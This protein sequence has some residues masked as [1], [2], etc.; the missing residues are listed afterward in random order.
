MTSTVD[1]STATTGQPIVSVANTSSA[2]SAAAAGGSVINVSQL[3]S[4]LVSAAQAPQ[5]TLI[6]NQTESVTAEISAL[7][8]LQSALSTFQSS[9]GALDTPE[10]L[11]CAHNQQQR[12]DSVGGKRGRRRYGRQLQRGRFAPGAGAAAAVG[13]CVREQQH[14]GRHRHPESVARR[15]ELQRHHRQQQ[16]YAGWD[17][18]GDQL[19]QRQSRHLLRP[20]SRAATAAPA[21]PSC[22]C[23][24]H[25]RAPPTRSRSAKPTAATDS[26]PSPTVR[27]TSRTTQYKGMAPRMRAIP[28]TV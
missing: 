19:G 10:C 27:A 7:G 9:L 4:E 15:H 26:P 14:R 22:C 11:Q 1:S 6:T 12:S 21:A 13:Q 28:S 24:P 5:E 23:P 17:R 18:C 8:T 20:C 2:A 25:S 3:V 16:R